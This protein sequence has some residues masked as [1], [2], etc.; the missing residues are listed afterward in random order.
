[1]TFK[2]LALIAAPHSSPF[3]PVRRWH[4]ERASLLARLAVADGFAPVFSHLNRSALFPG[5]E[6][7]DAIGLAQ[8][9]DLAMVEAVARRP[10][11]TF[12]ALLVADGTPCTETLH[13]W[14]LWQ[15]ARGLT[16]RQLGG[17]GSK[18]GTW[19]QWG[20]AFARVRLDQRHR[21]FCVPCS[22]AHSDALESSRPARPQAW[23]TR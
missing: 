3:P 19:E 5:D 18:V 16:G 13:K 4:I 1:M 14:R 8:A 12:Y 6:H 2:P 9:C 22:N 23:A 21:A 17:T 7:P 20:Q 11:S 10:S 15:S